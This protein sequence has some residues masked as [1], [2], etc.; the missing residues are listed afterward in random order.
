[1]TPIIKDE[2][3]SK[4]V[5]DED[6]FEFDQEQH[7]VARLFHQIQN[8]DTDVQFKLYT[9]ART[10]FGQG[11][12]LRVEYTLPPLVFASLSLAQRVWAREQKDGASLQVKTKKVFGFVHETIS[13]L[14]GRYPELALRLFL[15]AAQC[16]DSCSFEAISYEFVVQAFVC[17]EDEIND[18]KQQYTAITLV[19]ASL[20]HFL[21]F[22]QENYDTL[23]SKAT[24]HSAKLLKKEDQCRAVYECAHLFWP[25]DDAKPGHR[26]EKRV[27]A[28]LQ[29]SLKIANGCMGSQVHLFVEILNK[30]LYFFDRKCPSITVKYLKGL[31]ALVEEHIPQLDNSEMSKLAK[32]HYQNTIA[33]IKFK[34]SLTEDG[35]EADT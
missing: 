30:Y 25:G 20:Q 24:Q 23:I 12:M 27:L 16:A 32:T 22:G 8:T 6:K 33:H 2:K 3:D 34:Q 15:Q 10:Y 7:L 29:R 11:G 18:S 13:G 5:N 1:M 26:D 19:I 4:K 17:Y 9:T 28:C 35:K 31:I 21:N 14:S